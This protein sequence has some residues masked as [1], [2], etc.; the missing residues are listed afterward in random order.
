MISA[1]RAL[2]HKLQLFT[3]AV[4][5]HGDHMAAVS[6]VIPTRNRPE[7]LAAAIASARRQ[8]FGDREIIV[9]SNGET[10]ENREAS[11]T[12]AHLRWA[13]PRAKFFVI[14][15]IRKILLPY[16]MRQPRKMLM[17]SYCVRQPRKALLRRCWGR[18]PRKLS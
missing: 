12:V 17:L 1:H 14:P 15:R 18:Q 4:R 8:T 13:L 3:E 2:T 11:K 5:H 6:V 16:W 10:D 7:M 9:V